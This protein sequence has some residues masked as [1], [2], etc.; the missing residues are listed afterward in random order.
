MNSRHKQVK[1][2]EYILIA[3]ALIL[4]IT[5][6]VLTMVGS[7]SFANYY[8]DKI[9]INNFYESVSEFFNITIQYSGVFYLGFLFIIMSVL[10]FLLALMAFVVDYEFYTKKQK[11]LGLIL[12][13]INPQKIKVPSVE[14]GAKYVY[15]KNKNQK[16]D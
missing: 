13:K 4:L 3:I 14:V 1:K 6:F 15:E 11:E 9:D 10:F 7:G 2:M 8:V 16:V 12:T 5:G